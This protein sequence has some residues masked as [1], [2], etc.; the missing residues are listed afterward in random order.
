ML[1]GETKKTPKYANRIGPYWRLLEA[2]SLGRKSSRA[3]AK[4]AWQPD[5]GLCFD[6]NRYNKMFDEF[7][8]QALL[9][10]DNFSRRDVGNFMG[11]GQRALSAP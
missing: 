11:D 2:R 9:K 1:R 6:T 10:L 5:V 3:D 8:R 7:S 4:N